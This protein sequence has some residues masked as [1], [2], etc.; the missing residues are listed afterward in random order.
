MKTYWLL[1]LFALLS[2]CD[3][4]ITGPRVRGTG[5]TE[6]E[7]RTVNSF[8]R[9]DLKINAE[10]VVT[11]GSPQQVRV[12]AQRNVLD[13]LETELNGDELQIEFGKVNIR[14]HDPIKV[15]ITTPN[16]TEVQL[17]GSGKIRS[18][19][20][21]NTPT[22][23]VDVSG[24]GEVELN[25]AQ[26]TSL[27]TNLSG[28]GEMRLSGIS[29]SHNSST[30]GSGRISAYNLATQDTYASI[31]GSGRTYVQV[32]RT[33]NAEISGSGTVYYRGNPTVSTRITGSGRVLAGD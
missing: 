23:V 1:L 29:Q 8:N 19:A 28:S 16:L 31:T 5:P 11:Q 15:Y 30:S 6:S 2:A 26:A 4:D 10:V 18:G 27:R 13:V 32:S 14:D 24:S 9:I 21:L 20:P 22:C 33:L 17:S 25:F 7:V 12:E 3:N